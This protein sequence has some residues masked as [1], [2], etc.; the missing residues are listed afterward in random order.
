V[1]L[2]HSFISLL[3]HEGLSVV[4]VARQAGHS[5]EMTLST[6]AHVVDEH[7]LGTERRSAEDQI[8]AARGEDVPVLYPREGADP[9]IP[10]R[11]GQARPDLGCS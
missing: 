5:P 3:I 4:E 6:Y 7:S 9:H 8:R 1:S 10:S 11:G 2:R